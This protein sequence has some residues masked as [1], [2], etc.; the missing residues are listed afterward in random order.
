MSTTM[1][2]AIGYGMPID[3]F[4]EVTPLEG[5]AY[6]I[7]NQMYDIM[8]ENKEIKLPSTREEMKEY[9]LHPMVS[10]SILWDIMNTSYKLRSEDLF[11]MVGG[12]DDIEHVLFLPDGMNRDWLK[13]RSIFASVERSIDPE[14]DY[15]YGKMET[16]PYKYDYYDYEVKTYYLPFGHYPYSNDIMKPDGEPLKWIGSE[17]WFGGTPDS[18]EE[19]GAVPMPPVQMVYWLIKLGFLDHEGCLKLRPMYASWWG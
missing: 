18:Y 9:L 6:D 16:I 17:S 10:R 8:S 2:K 3:V 11:H 4:M 14:Q 15:S 5:D 1:Y 12:G 19:D 7:H 13:R